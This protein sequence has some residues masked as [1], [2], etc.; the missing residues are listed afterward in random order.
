MKIADNFCCVGGEVSFFK[1]E[2]HKS[3]H[4]GNL[5]PSLWPLEWGTG[6]RTG[7]HIS[8]TILVQPSL[9]AC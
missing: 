3:D 8:A 9:E 5:P 2:C 6:T 4:Q 7:P 1:D